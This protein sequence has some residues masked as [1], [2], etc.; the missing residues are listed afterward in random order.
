MTKSHGILSLTHSCAGT[1]CHTAFY[2]SRST[3]KGNFV[4]DLQESQSPWRLGCLTFGSLCDTSCLVGSLP[5][6]APPKREMELIIPGLLTPADERDLEDFLLDFEEDLKVLHSAQ[7][8]PSPGEKGVQTASPAVP[9]IDSE[10]IHDS[11]L[12]FQAKSV[13]LCGSSISLPMGTFKIQMFIPLE[14]V[15]IHI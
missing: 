10:A 13:P 9:T 2:M 12:H 7:C 15:S 3:S 1:L 6:I 8:S 4:G 14:L 11:W 5:G